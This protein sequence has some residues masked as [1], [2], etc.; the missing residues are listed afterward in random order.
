MVWKNPII[1]LGVWLAKG[2]FESITNKLGMEC[3]LERQ[4]KMDQPRPE[5][6]KDQILIEP[7]RLTLRTTPGGEERDCRRLQGT[8]MQECTSKHDQ[9]QLVNKNRT[10]R[11]MSQQK[12]NPAKD[13]ASQERQEYIIEKAPF[14]AWQKSLMTGEENNSPRN[15]K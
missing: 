12:R 6:E 3:V 7:K 14:E 13:Q 4:A 15:W 9:Y 2:H 11:K 8:I 1:K 10:S 5:E